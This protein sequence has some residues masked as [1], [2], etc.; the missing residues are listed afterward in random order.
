RQWGTVREDYSA[1]G[2][3]WNYVNFEMS[4]AYA[5][6]WGEDGI[7][8]LSDNKQNL[9]LAF[10][11]WNGKDRII[12]ERLFGLA[13]GQGNH[14]E[15]VKE[16]Y[17]YLDSTPTHSY[18][19]MLY[20]YP[21][22]AFPYEELIAVN[23]S[24]SK[25]EPEYELFDTGIFDNDEYF[26]I[27][28][29][30][31]KAAEEDIL[32]RVTAYNRFK[33]EAPLWIIPQVWFR[34]IWSWGN[35]EPKPVLYGEEGY[36]IVLE[37]HYV[38]NFN[39][40]YYGKPEL[41]F[42]ENETNPALFGKEVPKGK[43]FKDGINNYLVTGDK[44]YLNPEKTGTKA[45]LKYQFSIK[46]GE[47]ATI[48]LRLCKNLNQMP[49]ENVESIFSLR[50]Q[51]ADDFY[52]EIQKNV[53]D[54]DLRNIQRQAYAGMMWCKQYY[55]YNVEQWLDGDPAMENLPPQRKKGRNSKWRHLSNSNLISMPDKWEYPWYA[56]W[57]LAFHCVPLA[58]IDPEFAKRQLLLLLREYYMHPNG[59][60]PAYEW[61]FS[62]VNPPVH[63]WGAWQVYSI[64]K[65]LNHGVGDTDFLA[66]VF[67]KLLM[68]F[69]WWINQ[70][71]GDE[72]NL[73]E[74]G[75]LGLDN[76]GVFD[77]SQPL[78]LGGKMEQADAT[79]WMAMYA[80]NML[81]I[82]IELAKVKPY[83]QETASKFFE[84]FLN[85]ATALFQIGDEGVSMWDEE[86]EFYYDIIHFPN[87]QSVLLKVRSLVG[88]LPLFAV[89][90]FS[91]DLLRNN[92]DFLRRIE[93][94]FRN[95]KKLTDK[96]SRWFE[97]GKNETRMLSLVRI[98]RMKCILRRMLDEAEFLSE[99][100]VRALSRY[101]LKRPYQLVV[102]GTTYKVKY[103]PGESDSGM[104]GGNSNWRGPIWFPVNFMLILSLL[105]FHKFY[106]DE[107]KLE[108]PTGSGE[109]KTLKEIALQIAQRLINIFKKQP[110]GRRVVFGEYEKFWKDQH[111]CDYL[112]FYEYF[113]GDTGKGLG[114]SHQT[115][116]TGLIATLIDLVAEGDYTPL[117]YSEA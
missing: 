96:I 105:K 34:N 51:E 58:K 70:K 15:D 62:D 3:A 98:Y 14:G 114:A 56:A 16:I 9:C 8:G 65:Q 17:Y 110:D 31:A 93:H 87:E 111:F 53:H 86:D 81:R 30:Y 13:N 48:M 43:Y 20:K 36:P 109:E 103:L 113:H 90:V 67:L 104:F 2:D 11:F 26:D 22:R 4:R 60:I 85:I 5:Y 89:E 54:E 7:G 80:L 32:V 74:G 27:F 88:L 76:I 115:G 57:D 35:P 23:R 91:P 25:Q 79:S 21:Q 75:F 84:H 82:S 95:R 38:G 47:S 97:L 42:C 59:Q 77:R 46:G 68:N 106:G 49:F 116:W 61:S 72:N 69:T 108:F 107:L 45:G 73:F 71:D 102:H 44:A 66:K 92:P 28:I 18:M 99:Y 83:Y 24:R 1:N 50:K 12:K 33:E 19:K 41:M 78:P 64:D 6:R 112:L 55:Y 29:E 63:A 94:A 37:N 117:T 10:A 52:A 100:G 101:H 40:Y 39:L